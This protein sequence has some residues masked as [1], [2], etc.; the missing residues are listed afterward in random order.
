MPRGKDYWKLRHVIFREEKYCRSCRAKGGL[1][2]ATDLDHIRPAG[3]GGKDIKE[4]LQ[5]LCK[6]C[7]DIKTID[8]RLVIEMLAETPVEILTGRVNKRIR[9]LRKAKGMKGLSNGN[10]KSM[11]VDI[12][13]I[14]GDL[15]GNE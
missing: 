1:V 9:K 2:L 8:D 4:N 12:E 6:R 5:P 11:L 3:L 13:T 7:H 15:F 10:G 14:S